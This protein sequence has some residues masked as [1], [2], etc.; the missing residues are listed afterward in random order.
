MFQTSKSMRIDMPSELA[1]QDCQHWHTITQTMQIRLFHARFQDKMTS[2]EKVVWTSDL[3]VLEELYVGI[4][5][6]VIEVNLFSPPCLNGSTV[7]QFDLLER[8]VS[9]IRVTDESEALVGY[10][11]QLCSGVIF[12]D[13]FDGRYDRSDSSLVRHDFVLSKEQVAGV[14]TS[15]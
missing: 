5:V 7:W 15:T 3:R 4:N 12:Y 11:Y 14:E 8:V 2:F 1:I 13:Q 10:E 9:L 6:R